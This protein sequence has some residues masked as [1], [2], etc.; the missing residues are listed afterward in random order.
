MPSAYAKRC[1]AVERKSSHEGSR[2]PSPYA[3]KA[4]RGSLPAL[5]SVGRALRAQIY[6]PRV[7]L[8]VQRQRGQ[9]TVWPDELVQ[10]PECDT[11]L[12]DS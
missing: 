3:A 5:P 9:S 6:E 12:P 2:N 7:A 1:T 8:L 11:P 4:R 10:V